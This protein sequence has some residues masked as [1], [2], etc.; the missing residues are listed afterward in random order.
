M[1]SNSAATG[2]GKLYRSITLVDETSLSVRVVDKLLESK[3]LGLDAEGLAARSRG[4]ISMV[5]LATLWRHVYIFDVKESEALFEEGNLKILLESA[6]ML[7]VVHDFRNIAETFYNTFGVK[8]R[9][10]FDTHSAYQTIAIQRGVMESR[11]LGMDELFALYEKPPNPDSTYIKC[12]LNK[13]PTCF[14]IRPISTC[15]ACY[16]GFNVCCLLSVCE[17]QVRRI[18]AKYWP[19][20]AA[21]SDDQL[22]NRTNSRQLVQQA[23][24]QATRDREQDLKCRLDESFPHNY[25]V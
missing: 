11:V 21:L 16:T 9:K 2:G 5:T 24:H 1:A 17:D 20:L 3:M 14:V 12:W 15:V 23:L 10:V 6:K 25:G 13:D 22:G 4:R 18:R 19:L 7:K 8:V